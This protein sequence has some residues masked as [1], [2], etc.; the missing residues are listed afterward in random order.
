MKST[1][2]KLVL[3]SLIAISVSIVAKSQQQ[4]D[5]LL[6]YLE[7]AAKNNPAVLQKFNEYQAALQKIPQVGSLPDPELSMGIFLSPMELVSGN[8]VADIRLMQMFPWFGVIK[9]AK[10]EM[11]LM[12][13]AKYESFRDAKLQVFFEVQSTW[14]DLYKIQQNIDISEKNIEI[15]RTLERLSLVKYKS[16]QTGSSNSTISGGNMSNVNTQ[17]T[18][19]GSTGM[20]SMGG[21]TNNNPSATSNQQN[22]SMQSNSMGSTSSGSGLADLYRIQIEIGELENNIALLKNQQNTIIARFNSFLNRPVKSTVS[23]PDTLKPDSLGTSL[24]AVSDSMLANNPMLGMLQYEQQSLEARKKMVSRMGYPMVGLGVNYSLINKS[25]MSTSAMN[26]KDMIMP[27]VTV[28]LPI[29]RKKYKAMQTEADLM[30][31]A[32]E[33]GYN[34]ASNSL[35]TEYY[36][37]LQFY[38]DAQRRM[39][40]YENQS[41]LAKKSLDIMIKSFSTSGTGLSDLLRIRQQLL[42][43]ET[44][45]VEAVTDYNTAIAWLKRL[46]AFSQ[47]Q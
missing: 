38:Q 19:S 18:S 35:Q 47:I 6:H 7:I 29:Y 5:S 2:Y 45:Q 27:M 16:S 42:D 36:E 43:Y 23:L 12:A 8:Q 31:S 37:A 39:K 21:N 25:D 34:A 41:Q 20:N 17:N 22:T 15:L 13:K 10:D 3:L 4:S 28:T 14:Y 1:I 9:N 40:L 44:K 30:K 46:M 24:L 26:G 33:Q 11:S 32:T